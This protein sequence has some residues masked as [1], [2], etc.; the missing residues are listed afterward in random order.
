MSSP[1]PDPRWAR[2]VGVG[3]W[4]VVGRA[5]A[6]PVDEPGASPVE[7]DAD[8]SDR[9]SASP[10]VDDS[11][12][13]PAE[14]PPIPDG[15]IPPTLQSPMSVQYPE[16]LAA[17]PSSP[18]GEVEVAFVIGIDGVT[19]DIEVTRRLHDELDRIAVEAVTQARYSPATFDGGAVE[20]ETSV[21]FRFTPPPAPPLPTPQEQE[22]VVEVAD[23][24]PS[25]VPTGPVRIRGVALEGGS[26]QPIP[27]MRV[28]AIP[29][30]GLPLG[31]VRRR[32]SRRWSETQG[33]PT[34]TLEATTDQEGA[35][36]LAGVP[37]GRIL[38]IFISPGFDRLEY[39]VQLT[40]STLVEGKYYA[41]RLDNNPYRTVVVAPQERPAEITRREITTEELTRIPGT[42]GDPLKGLQNFPGMAR[43]PFGIGQ[44]IIR[45][46]APGDSAVYLGGHELPTLFHFGGLQSVFNA[47]MIASAAYVPSNFDSPYG[48]A[49]GG[50]VDITPKTPRRDGFHGYVDA[51]LYD[52]SALVQGPV[53]RGSFAVAARRSY[54]D[55]VLRG[56]DA[57]PLAPRYWDYQGLFEHP[58]GPGVLGV[59]LLGSDDQFV[60]LSDLGEGFEFTS[61]F[62]RADLYYR[63]KVGKWSLY[64][65]PSFSYVTETQGTS[66]EDSYNTSTRLEGKYRHDDHFDLLFGTETRA[67]AARLTLM[68]AVGGGFG[69]PG[70]GSSQ[71]A[72]SETTVPY[73]TPALYATG[74]IRWGAARPAT[75]S[76]SVRMT[77]YAT[78]M[79]QVTVD[80]RL[81]AKWD[82]A[83]K[84]SLKAGVGLYSQAPEFVELDET[85]GNPD[86][87]PEHSVQSSLGARWQLPYDMSVEVTGFYKYLWDIVV[88][89]DR[90]VERGGQTVPQRWANT[91]IGHSYGAELLFR[92]D[93][94]KNLYGW[95]AYTLSRTQL[96]ERDAQPLQLA[97]F[98]QTHIL[99]LVAGYKLPRNWNM[100]LR[101]RLTSGNPTTPLANGIYDSTTG[102]Y[103]PFAAPEL[104]GRLPAFHQLDLRVDKTWTLRLIR[105]MAYLD[106]QNLYNAQNAEFLLSSYDYEQSVRLTSLPFFPSLG[107]R[108]DF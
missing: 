36:E 35:F 86:L 58:V 99:N 100:G 42:Q 102:S 44:L 79:G 19:K 68:S 41:T 26:R 46:A 92:R 74:T 94:S 32:E 95:L 75:V 101:F 40:P 9:P 48:D 31:R 97:P 29:G 33:E 89:S 82:V 21:T 17:G 98:D 39:A 81:N 90:L 93:F 56:F 69:P 5:Y 51:D 64:A 73:V 76:P 4:L 38:L 28:V 24:A 87:S 77:A 1:A 6:A 88:D 108:L 104:S 50:L 57:V 103:T 20:I 45:G 91:G 10:P 3:L 23:D 65:S 106:I 53:G 2:L 12:F 80:P 72:I 71:N 96:R 62:H 8:P 30:E 60:A 107:L 16:G 52:A 49:T 70:G 84:W 15:L 85:F 55:G 83:P 37:D 25:P 61:A 14:P 63:Q 43:T 59:R 11:T 27:S 34:W 22:P 18:E 67:G 47:D 13:A 54:V 78:P 105:I 7:P 66:G